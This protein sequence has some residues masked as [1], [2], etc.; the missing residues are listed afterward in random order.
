MDTV[1]TLTISFIVFTFGSMLVAIQVAGGQMTPR[2]IATTL[3]RDNVIRSTVGLFIFSLLFATGT[4]ARID[5]AIPH[6][7]ATVSMV[8]GIA[9]VTAFLFLIDYTARLL[10]PITIVWRIGEQ[11]IK[12][13]E[14]VYPDAVGKP[15]IPVRPARSL[16][17]P[18]RTVDHRGTSAIVLAVNIK[19]LVSAA[20]TADGI[21]E[22]I[23]RVGDFVATDE[24]LFRLYGGATAIDDRALRAQVAFGP[25][26]TIEQEFDLRVPRHC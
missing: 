1:V 8:L 2:I 21:I 15:R 22:F 9:S 12:V 13:V 11:G 14:A 16:G 3:L 24:P 20:R 6:F 19:S 26:R 23:P 4:K 17:P 10:R 7:A 18:A 25:E 5:G